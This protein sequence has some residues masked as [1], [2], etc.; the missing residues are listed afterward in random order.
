MTPFMTRPARVR[1]STAVSV[2]SRLNGP[3]FLCRNTAAPAGVVYRSGARSSGTEAQRQKLW[4]DAG[5][6]QD[7][8]SSLIRIGDRIGSMPHCLDVW[9]SI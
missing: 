2:S 3:G 6:R 1:L 7:A 8:G 9:Q 4:R 5:K